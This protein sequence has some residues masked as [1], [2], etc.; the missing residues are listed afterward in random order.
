MVVILILFAVLITKAMIEIPPRFTG[1]ASHQPRMLKVSLNTEQKDGK[2]CHAGL[3][4]DVRYYGK[5]MCDEAEE[6]IGHLLSKSL[7]VKNLAVMQAK[8][9]LPSRGYGRE[10]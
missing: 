9:C 3:A 6:R 1:T 2:C 7:L 10:R 5:W 4:E 8:H